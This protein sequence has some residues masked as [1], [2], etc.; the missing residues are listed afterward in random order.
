MIKKS[1]IFLIF[2]LSITISY[3]TQV[4]IG[5]IFVKNNEEVPIE[6]ILNKMSLKEGQIF[7]TEE[8]V[9]DYVKLKKE[10]YIEDLK[11][12]PQI[13]NG[14]INVVVDIQENIDAVRYLK[15][16]GIVPV[17]EL[18]KID[19][20]LIIKSI[21][22]FGNI[23]ISKEE[24]LKNVP[25]K[26]GGFF[27][28][29]KILEGQER[30]LKTGYFRE[31]TPE[32]LKYKDGI[33]IKYK[34]LENP[35][36]TGIKIIGNTLF[37]QDELTKDFITKP[38][39]IYNI[40]NLKKDRDSLLKKYYDKGYSL[41]NLVDMRLDENYNLTIQVSEGIVRGI[42]FRKIA[43]K[44]DGMRRKANDIKLRTKD[45]VL[46]REVELE[47]G[48]PFEREKFE[49]TAS[50][51]FKLG[52]FKNVT[53]EFKDI[54]GDPD[55]KIVVFLLD[56]N[57]SATYT[58]SISYGSSTGLLG[59]LSLEDKNFKGKNQTAALSYAQGT[60]TKTYNLSFSDP[61][62]KGTERL[63][64]GWS[65]YKKNYTDTSSTDA[66][67]VDKIGGSASLGK[68][69]SKRVR[70]NGTIKYEQIEE[71]NEDEEVQ[72][73]YDIITLTPSFTYDTR[74]NIYDATKGDYARI[75]LQLGKILGSEE[76]AVTELELRKYKLA[77]SEKNSMAYRLM[78]G[79]A[80]SNVK[81][82]LKFNVGGGSSLRGYDYG[83]FQGVYQLY[84]N[85]ENRTKLDDN[86][87]FVLFYD[88]G[89]AWENETSFN[90][91][92]IN[93][94]YSSASD[95]VKFL[96][97]IKHSYGFGIRIQTPLGPLRF[98]YGWPIGDSD[99]KG[100]QFYFNIGQMF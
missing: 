63:S 79:M 99:V 89:R 52:L 93:G 38:G 32:V 18:E 24:I 9:K 100:G 75:S 34:V 53:Q 12:F 13:E 94:E 59:S 21:E 42:Q 69:L 2:I 20:S 72:S 23:N 51:L 19:K 95:Y 43:R 25:V 85:I 45:F 68:G 5:K 97:D 44:E 78:T 57:K 66:Y 96:H 74:N 70:V 3:A 40:N 50:N 73:D 14:E 41:A 90:Q 54:E 64:Y 86:F 1:F 62:V 29:T 71:S 30:I 35:V 58:G 80:S 36:I 17:S 7:T 26:I 55:G 48:K 6:V 92:L 28:K 4:K 65:I 8:M 60:S 87:Q 91:G 11:I 15:E 31:V 33:Y 88:F 77:L 67:Y 98:D 10:K 49:K 39:E 37:T 27:S 61:W 83:D 84:G 81:E 76:F 82:G 47:I 22:V 16:E 56:E 46:R